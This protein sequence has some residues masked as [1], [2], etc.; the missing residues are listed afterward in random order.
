MPFFHS[1]ASE[2]ESALHNNLH[3]MN[4]EA[5]SKSTQEDCVT[6]DIALTQKG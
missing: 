4:K 5:K 3:I 6:P 2:I 1:R